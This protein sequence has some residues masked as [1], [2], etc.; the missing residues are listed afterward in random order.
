MSTVEFAYTGYAYSEANHI[1]QTQF[2]GSSVTLPESQDNAKQ[3]EQTIAQLKDELQI[4]KK[5]LADEVTPR[6][7]PVSEELDRKYKD[8]KEK[9]RQLILDK[10]DLQR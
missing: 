8:L 9:N 1:V 10:Q 2:H 5:R 3:Y 7:D 6:K 4:L